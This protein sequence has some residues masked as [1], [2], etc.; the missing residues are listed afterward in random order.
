[1][2]YVMIA[3]LQKQSCRFFFRNKEKIIKEHKSE[4]IQQILDY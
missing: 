2:V 3:N 1:M 4:T